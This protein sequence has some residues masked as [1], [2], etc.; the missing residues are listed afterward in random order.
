MLNGSALMCLIRHKDL[1]DFQDETLGM[2]T[3]CEIGPIEHEHQKP[4]GP[5]GIAIG[6]VKKPLRKGLD[7]P[8]KLSRV[9]YPFCMSETGDGT[10]SAACTET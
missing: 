10:V 5:H 8:L 2:I 3:G 1:S 7:F 4:Q 9:H 6:L